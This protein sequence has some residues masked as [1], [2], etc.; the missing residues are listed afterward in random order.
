MLKVEFSVAEEYRMFCR[1]HNLK[2]ENCPKK[3][4]PG[5]GISGRGAGR[6][7]RRK[8]RPARLNCDILKEILRFSHPLRSV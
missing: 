5:I 2:R 7:L 1:F 3:H 4:G 8:E 6:I